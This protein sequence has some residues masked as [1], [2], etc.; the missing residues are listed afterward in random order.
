[1]NAPGMACTFVNDKLVENPG[2]LRLTVPARKAARRNAK[3][4]PAALQRAYWLGFVEG[5][6]GVELDDG[7]F[8]LDQ[9]VAYVCG[10]IDGSAWS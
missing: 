10:G 5:C 1:M 6:T 9:Q 3:A 7:D 4:F 8:T 2:L